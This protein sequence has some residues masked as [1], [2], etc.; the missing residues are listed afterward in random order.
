MQNK[1]NEGQTLK[2]KPLSPIQFDKNST[3][4]NPINKIMLSEETDKEDDIDNY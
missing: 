4:P 1:N 3:L 2:A